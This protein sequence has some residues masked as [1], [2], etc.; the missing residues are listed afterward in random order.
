MVNASGSPFNY[1]SVEEV[2]KALVQS[3]AWSSLLAALV[4][5]AEYTYANAGSVFHN[6]TIAG[7]ATYASLFTLL[8]ARGLKSDTYKWKASNVVE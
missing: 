8:I 6:P 1:I 4:A 2:K 5:V 7:L 3:G